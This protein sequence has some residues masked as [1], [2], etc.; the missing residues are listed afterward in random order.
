MYKSHFASW[1]FRKCN[2]T[3]H[4]IRQAQ[5]QIRYIAT[6]KKLYHL[7]AMVWATR[8]YVRAQFDS[9]GWIATSFTYE[10][11]QKP[12]KWFDLRA[13]EIQLLYSMHQMQQRQPSKAIETL[14]NFFGC[15]MHTAPYRHPTLLNGH[16]LMS[17][18]IIELCAIAG[19]KGLGLIRSLVNYQAGIARILLRGLEPMRNVLLETDE[20]SKI[21]PLSLGQAFHNGLLASANCLE[22]KLGPVHPTVLLTWVNLKWYWKSPIVETKQLAVRYKQALA[23]S[24]AVLGPNDPMTICLLHDFTHYL[25]YGIGDQDGARELVSTLEERAG[26]LVR[27]GLPG[28]HISR[29]YAFAT[30]AL[31]QFALMD[32]QIDECH[33]IFKEA[34]SSLAQ[35]GT[36]SPMQMEMLE[37]DREA[38]IVSWREKR[39][40]ARSKLNF[41]RPR[42][43]DSERELYQ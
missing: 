20:I 21:D 1:G 19:D 3:R 31:G 35:G 26:E 8:D 33:E 5:D 23:E 13:A 43:M 39:E 4:P 14:N 24:E 18:K 30:V 25:F 29:A 42:C 28:P 38:M 16:W 7:E 41:A 10:K 12:P 27:T 32:D 34:M 40:L 17:Q 6:P 15:L 36:F 2:R 37:A 11:K 9:H 22:E